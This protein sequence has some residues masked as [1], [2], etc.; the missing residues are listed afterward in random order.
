MPP[1]L[2]DALDSLSP[3][4]RL[5]WMAHFEG[6]TSADQLSDWLKRAGCPVGPTTI[7]TYRR[8]Q[9]RSASE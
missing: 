6:G 3:E 5:A 4:R 9:K 8:R 7:K 2:A 1:V